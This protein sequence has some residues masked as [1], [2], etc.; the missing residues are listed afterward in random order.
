MEL[1][2]SKL[3]VFFVCIFKLNNLIAIEGCTVIN[4]FLTLSI[5]HLQ[6]KETK[7]GQIIDLKL[8]WHF[9]VLEIDTGNVVNVLSQKKRQYEL[10]AY[11][12]T[13]IFFL[14]MLLGA[15]Q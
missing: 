15:K 12:S 14:L 3:A 13:D 9:V 1:I 5:Q 10:V 6:N 2:Q 7:F 11:K 8:D 4:N